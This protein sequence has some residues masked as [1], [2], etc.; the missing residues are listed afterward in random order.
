[1]K[2]TL[3]LIVG[4]IIVIGLSFA[5]NPRKREDS[6]CFSPGGNCAKQISNLIRSCTSSVDV[7]IFDINEAQIVSSLLAQKNK[8]KIRIVV[9]RR[10]ASADET[11]AVDELANAGIPL[12][13]GR[14]KALMHN[15][16]TIV[17]RSILETG[18][19][20]YTNNGNLNNNENII[21]LT[22]TAT[23]LRYQNRFDVI[24]DTATEDKK[25]EIK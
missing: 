3:G 10:Q 7:A 20:N 24:W 15:K 16:F 14:Q 9:D 22:D 25:E 19:A 8:C 21:F 4:L 1:M 17:D 12:R 6:V 18:S 11:S 2:T 13:Y 5:G 23:V